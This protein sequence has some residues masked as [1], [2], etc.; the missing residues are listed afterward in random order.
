VLENEEKLLEQLVLSL[1]LC[2][3]AI[4]EVL[5]IPLLVRN[6]MQELQVKTSW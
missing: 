5:P 6:L 3:D 1:R 2:H 4:Q